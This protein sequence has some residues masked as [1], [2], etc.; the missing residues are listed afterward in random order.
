MFQGSENVAR[1]IVKIVD[2]RV[3]GCSVDRA[4]ISIFSIFRF[5]VGVKLTFYS[6]PGLSADK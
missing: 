2:R 6:D 3:Q 1:M 5:K 4:M